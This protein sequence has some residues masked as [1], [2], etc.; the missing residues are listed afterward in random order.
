[1]TP[2]KLRLAMAAMGKPETNVGELCESWASPVH[3]LSARLTYWRTPR[4]K[5]ASQVRLLNSDFP[6]ADLLSALRE[7]QSCRH[8][9]FSL[10][11][12]FTPSY[13]SGRAYTHHATGMITNSR[14]A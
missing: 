1:M 7:C 4:W 9:E 2:A 12:C 3:A 5:A 11:G 6:R 13:L 10:S 14:P 8:R